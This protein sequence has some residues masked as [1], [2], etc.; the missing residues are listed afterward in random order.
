MTQETRPNY[1]ILNSPYQ[2]PTQYWALDERFRQT[3][4]VVDGRRPSGAYLS[5]PMARGGEATGA[6]ALDI[7]PHA[8]INRIRDEVEEW[9]KQGYAGASRSTQE[10]LTHW[11][12]DALDQRP[13][14]CQVE[15]AETLI[16][17]LEI[18]PKSK[19]EGW[20]A[21]QREVEEANALW[22]NELPRLAVKMATGTG[23]T[24]V[25]AMLIVWLAFRQQGPL[26]I[27]VVAPNLTV[28]TRLQELNPDSEAG[29]ELYRQLVPPH[30]VF[31]A[32]RVR[33]AIV[34]FQR[35]QRQD[36]LSVAGEKDKATGVAK[37]LLR[38]H[39]Q[40]TDE[41]WRETQEDMVRRV[42]NG[43]LPNAKSIFV[44]NDEAHHCY[45]PAEARRQGDLE[46][47]RYEEQA[48]LWFSALSE[49]ARQ[50]RLEQ[51]V[52][53]SATP[54]YLRRPIGLDYELFPWT[55]TDYPLIEAVEA[56]LTKIPQVPVRDDSAAADPL[57]RNT[58][59][60]VDRGHRRLARDAIP[61]PVRR[62]LENMHEDYVKLDKQYA[63][64]GQIPVM[65]A[66][67][68]DKKNAEAL[69]QHI[70]G[71]HDEETNNWVPGAYERFSNV[72]E[73]GPL[74]D[75]KTLLIHSGI[76]DTSLA[77]VSGSKR[78]A[79]L[80]QSYFPAGTEKESVERIREVFQS[81]GQRDKPGARIRCVV[82]VSMLSE[83]W[84]VRTVTHIFGFRAFRSTLLCEQVAGRAL[85]RTN[86]PEPGVPL[87]PQYARIFGV[88][89]SFMR[90]GED[91]PPPPPP[92][93][94][95]V[96]SIPG[97]E[98]FRVAFPNLSGYRIELPQARVELSPDRVKLFPIQS[99]P[100]PTETE[101]EGIV[102]DP[103]TFTHH[104]ISETRAAYTIAAAA[105]DKIQLSEKVQEAEI[106]IRR[107]VLFASLLK[108]AQAWK[109]H[110]NVEYTTLAPIVESGI[111][112]RAAQM[113][114]DAC[115]LH[116]GKRQI[117]PV[118]A[119]EKDPLQQRVI[120]TAKVSFSTVL[121]HRFP[122]DPR[123]QCERSEL[124]AAACHT[125]SEVWLA[126]ALDLHAGILAWARNFRLGWRIPYFDPQ[127]GTW[128]YYEPDFVARVPNAADGQP[129][130]IVIEFK[131]EVDEDAV[132]KRQEVEGWWMPAV[133]N[134]SDPSCHGHWRYVFIAANESISDALDIAVAAWEE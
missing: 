19:S 131:G 13:F 40:A 115:V 95:V 5:V 87:K 90:A 78:V 60:S 127:G 114:A 82:A 120:D 107:S 14:F 70:A 118:F 99:G 31:P 134:S 24:R 27:L 77:E 97:R 34:N 85:R 64:A 51:I 16:W 10:L 3:D 57:Y 75:P 29:A 50:D 130:H 80:Q 4:V 123:R 92:E 113:L 88:P 101:V 25:M 28:R 110:P 71:Y 125:A 108:A 56:G 48:A 128:R 1:P 30:R 83:G 93:P 65:I 105:V 66:V 111:S 23:K 84:D 106:P 15:A 119:D 67:T 68:N 124:N 112:E 7:E 38:P 103:E 42:V 36:L 6:P 33:V 59:Q 49:L 102:G 79:K 35:F 2:A 96:E 117:L 20:Q 86:F 63:V 39:A 133:N 121:Q 122:D 21:I 81:I 12:S 18:G 76:E 98:R 69:Y 37:K 45:R 53:L 47:R 22:N 46:E 11:Q 26:D 52:D 89:F 8:R 73:N 32:G 116:E 58:Y 55:I 44:F 104:R 91:I 132:T 94:W 126:R 61:E 41:R 100:T 109:D 72:D 9:R 129:R 62:L 43:V 54:M 17:L 74:A